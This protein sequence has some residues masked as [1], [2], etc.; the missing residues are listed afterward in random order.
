MFKRKEVSTYLN[1]LTQKEVVRHMRFN[2]KFLIKVIE[3]NEYLCNKSISPDMLL[4]SSSHL[5]NELK[6]NYRLSYFL[7]FIPYSKLYVLTLLWQT[8]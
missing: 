5:F 2:F 1:R 8:S 6:K 3:S 4:I 7:Q